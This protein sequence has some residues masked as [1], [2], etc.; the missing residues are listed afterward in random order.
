M[1]L[2]GGTEEKAPQTTLD[3]QMLVTFDAGLLQLEP[4][5]P[6]GWEELPT[7]PNTR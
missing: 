5:P 1:C 6:S 3:T 7:A 2:S 4:E